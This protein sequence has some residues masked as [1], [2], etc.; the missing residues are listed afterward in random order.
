MSSSQH[1]EHP[2]PLTSTTQSSSS[3]SSSNSSTC[4]GSP[5][6]CSTSFVTCHTGPHGHHP[7]IHQDRPYEP[8]HFYTCSYPE[9]VE[10]ESPAMYVT[11]SNLAQSAAA[12]EDSPAAG[13]AV[14]RSNIT[15]AM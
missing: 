7:V 12:T 11:G 10:T 6:P 1:A 5:V 13:D 3:C 4:H 9:A 14:A 15:V 2:R 8:C